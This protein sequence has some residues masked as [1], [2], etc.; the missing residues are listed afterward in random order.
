MENGSSKDLDWQEYEAVTKYIYENLGAKNGIKIKGYG[1][2]FRVTG[3]S[4][5]KYQIDVLT[6]QLDGDNS[7]LTAIECKFMKKKVTKEIV[8]K[9]HSVMEDADIESGIIVC[10][11]GYTKGTMN[12]AAYKGIKLVELREVG[13]NDMNG[14]HTIDVGILD[15]NLKGTLTRAIITTI[16]LGAKVITDQNEIMAMHYTTMFN[17]DGKEVYFKTCLLEFSRDLQNGEDVMKTT[18]KIYTPAG[19]RLIWRCKV[20]ELVIEKVVITGFLTKTDTSSR[21]SFQLVDEVWMIMNEIFEKK[22]YKL[23]K[24]GLLFMDAD[25]S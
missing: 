10:K 17:S 1:R 3:K 16:D 22:A 18:T 9:L 6:E 4:G 21:Q 12:Y 25:E 14:E 11:A 15:I 2:N 5:E 7:H 13:A 20:E 23:S 19:G 24:S 8:M